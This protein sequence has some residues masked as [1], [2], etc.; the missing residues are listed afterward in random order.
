[1][2]INASSG[3]TIATAHTTAHATTPEQENATA[4]A[5]DPATAPT[6]PSRTSYDLT[7]NTTSSPT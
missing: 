3:P 6:A 7:T 1:M 5:A 4:A 2:D